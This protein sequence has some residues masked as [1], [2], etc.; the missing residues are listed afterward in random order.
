MKDRKKDKSVFYKIT[1]YLPCSW[2]LHRSESRTLSFPKVRSDDA[3][4]RLYS[5]ARS[6]KIRTLPKSS[7]VLNP[8]KCLLATTAVLILITKPLV[9]HS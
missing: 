3:E 6:Q 9:I 2:L 8:Q 4:F 5:C 1:Y 7:G